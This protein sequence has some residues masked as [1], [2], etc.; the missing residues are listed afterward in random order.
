MTT[1]SLALP[2]LR[3]RYAEGISVEQVMTGLLARIDAYEDGAVW[4]ARVSPE[5][6]LERARALDT[7]PHVEKVKLALFGVPFAVKD[8]IDVAGLPTTAACPA[9]AYRPERSATV[10]ERLEAAGAIVLGKTNLDQFA[11][12][13]NGTRSPHGAPRSVFNK[14][15]IS[16]GSSSGSSVAVAAGLAS[17]SLGTDTAGSGRVPAAFNNI[18][19]LKPTRGLLSTR[20]VVPACRSLDCVSVFALTVD[21]ALSVTSVAAGFDAEDP[22]SRAAIARP[23]TPNRRIA[24]PPAAHINDNCDPETARLFFSSVDLLGQLGFEMSEIDYAPFAETAALLYEGPWVA[25][26]T[27]AVG[28]F[29]EAHPDAI[30][31]VVRTIV[32]G[33]K[34][35]SAAEGFEASYRLA[36]LH[37]QAHALLDGFDAMLVPTAPAIFTVAQMEADPIA[38]NSRLG[39]YT[40]FMNLLDLSGI[41]I[42]AGFGADGL[43]VGITLAGQAF[44]EEKL[45]DIARLFAA[46]LSIEPGGPLAQKEECLEIVA[47]G[48]HMSGLPLN[49][50]LTARG[51]TLVEAGKTAPHYRLYALP[52]GPPARPGLLRHADGVAIAIEVWSMPLRHFGSFMAGIPAPL[53]IGTVE[54]ASGRK[55][56]GF[57]CEP[58]GLEGATDVS[59][60]GGWRNY[61]ASK[62][63]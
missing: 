26:R 40:N 8:N 1:T 27:A 3:T 55:V 23:D 36:A 56:K 29:V 17:F 32:E 59:G 44:D 25:E 24:M 19:G 63:N 42:P 12:G 11:T 14:D 49:R 35:R 9:F 61:L 6:L 34:G 22:F 43:P 30:N 38:L 18:V 15:Y 4:I 13:L 37:R 51:A 31:P 62:G 45:G 39:L 5:K 10:I 33:G 41:A 60:F 50:E 53:C 46:A 47:V 16:G 21:D 7:L 58:Y 57:L 52:G 48:A 20:G 54:L 2:E 28:G